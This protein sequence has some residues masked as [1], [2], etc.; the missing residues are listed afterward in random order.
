[1]SRINR[2]IYNAVYG[3]FMTTFLFFG[4]DKEKKTR[5]DK[6]IL[7]PGDSRRVAVFPYRNTF[8]SG[9]GDKEF[10]K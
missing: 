5:K 2:I 3:D 9:K 6:C 8:F 1:M 4:K 10:Y 7:N